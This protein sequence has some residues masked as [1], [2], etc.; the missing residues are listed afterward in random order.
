[1]DV[2]VHGKNAPCPTQRRIPHIVTSHS[3]PST[4]DRASS[5][6]NDANDFPIVSPRCAVAS[7]AKKDASAALTAANAAPTA[8]RRQQAQEWDRQTNTQ[9]SEMIDWNIDM[10]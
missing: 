8:A 5:I 2:S 9:V 7:S 6:P 3:S 4:R 10:E 1:M